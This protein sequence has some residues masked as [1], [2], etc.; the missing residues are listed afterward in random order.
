MEEEEPALYGLDKE[1]Q[2]RMNAK[3]SVEREQEAR[4]WIEDLLQEPFP[5]DDFAESLKDGV[6]LCKVID[7]LAPGRVKFKKSRMPFIQME[8]IS[9][10]LAGAEALGVP[11]HDLFQTV[12]LFEQKNMM[13]VVDAIHSLSR[14]GYKAG[15]CSK[16]LGPK[17]ADKQ[18]STLTKEK[19]RAAD[20]AINTYQYG[21]NKGSTQSGMS[22]FGAQREIV[23]KDPYAQYK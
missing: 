9:T 7:K 18:A 5:S 13:Q 3:Y 12:D 20:A 14:F 22:S 21:Y 11:K 16:Y 2:E 8:N 23:G 6:I 19:L 15:M 10:F 1:I 17:L 4:Q